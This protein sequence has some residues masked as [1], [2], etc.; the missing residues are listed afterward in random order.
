[1]KLQYNKTIASGEDV[2]NLIAE[3]DKNFKASEVP[4]AAKLK[5]A[6]NAC[7]APL[8]AMVSMFGGAAGAAYPPASQILGAVSFVVNAGKAREAAMEALAELFVKLSQS[9]K[10]LQVLKAGFEPSSDLEEI[11]V[12]ILVCLLTILDLAARRRKK[13]TKSDVWHRVKTKLK[14]DSKEFFRVLL[15]SEDIDIKSAV[16]T[17]DKLTTE[18]QFMIAAQTKQDATV[19]RR[20]VIRIEGLSL[21]VEDLVQQNL[22]VSMAIHA[23][24]KDSKDM[25]KT[26]GADVKEIKSG[27]SDLASMKKDFKTWQNELRDIIKR[28]R[29]HDPGVRSKDQGMKL[30]SRALYSA[31]VGN[32]R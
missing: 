2:I 16:E 4:E 20:T 28:P 22:E 9:T 25:A 29:E 23:D 24:L 21:H 32:I 18:Q 17:L 13:P 15:W 26:T 14:D 12:G 8:T 30:R 6:V 11:A 19:T 1:M 5:T 27:M 7:V 3:A 31:D 10:R